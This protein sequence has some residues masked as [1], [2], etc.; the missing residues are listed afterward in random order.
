MI[1]SFFARFDLGRLGYVRAVLNAMK[2]EP[3]DLFQS[4]RSI[5]FTMSGTEFEH[6]LHTWLPETTT[7]IGRLSNAKKQIF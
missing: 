1:D 5:D 3:T 6:M 7:T 4:L 2:V